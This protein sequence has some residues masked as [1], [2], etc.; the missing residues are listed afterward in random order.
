MRGVN[1]EMVCWAKRS[2]AVGP[3]KPNGLEVGCE[4]KLKKMGGLPHGFGPKGFRAAENEVWSFGEFNSMNLKSTEKK[5]NSNQAVGIFAKMEILEF[6]QIE[7]KSKLWFKIQ[8][9]GDL[10]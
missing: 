6:E 1:A 5:L 10:K 9:K 8:N 7:F 3:A 2:N 4:V